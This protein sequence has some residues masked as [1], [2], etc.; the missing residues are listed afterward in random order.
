[1][2]SL[3]AKSRWALRPLV[4]L[5]TIPPQHD[6]GNQLLRIE[7]LRLDEGRIYVAGRIEPATANRSSGEDGRVQP[8]GWNQ[9]A[10]RV[11][12]QPSLPSLARA[13]VTRPVSRPPATSTTISSS[14]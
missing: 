11:S 3:G 9:S 8:F 10:A 5:L 4:A 13:N 12:D 7:Q 6:D 2:L 14:D 1:M